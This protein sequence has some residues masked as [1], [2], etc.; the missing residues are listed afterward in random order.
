MPCDA[1][2]TRLTRWGGG[3]GFKIQC[4]LKIKRE[5]KFSPSLNEEFESTFDFIS[6]QLLIRYVEHTTTWTMSRFS[7][8]FRL[9][10]FY[11]ASTKK[12]KLYDLRKL[13]HRGNVETQWMLEAMIRSY[14]VEI[15]CH[16]LIWKSTKC[17]YCIALS[18]CMQQAKLFDHAFQINTNRSKLQ[19]NLWPNPT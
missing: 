2:S 17:I 12:E 7:S 16:D 13:T 10:K 15:L 8:C 5:V 18:I 1:L 19:R 9:I 6:D 4:F 3:K 14:N 11:I